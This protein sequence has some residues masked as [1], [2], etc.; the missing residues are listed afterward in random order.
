MANSRV[1]YSELSED[2]LLLYLKDGDHAAFGE[3]FIRYGELMYAHAY[4]KLRN[5]NDA[6][7]SV[8]EMFLKIWQLRES[9]VITKNM[10]AY[11]F[12]LLR[13]H[14][15]NL[16]KHKQVAREYR[17]AFDIAN[18]E[19]GIY[20]DTLVREKQFAALIEDEIANLPPRMRM[21][22]EMRRKQHLSNKE[23]AQR[24][25]ITESTAADQMKKALRI[26]R[27]RFGLFAFIVYFLHLK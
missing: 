11:L 15:F 25:G 21:V 8:Q 1:I 6:R 5:E 18:E 27:N 20:T 16:I 12:V 26:L 17:I 22:F 7:D 10:G 24:L 14:I 9:L 23:V 3:L 4:N 13:N 2:D 19:S